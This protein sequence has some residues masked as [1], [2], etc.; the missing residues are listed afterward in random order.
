LDL[1]QVKNQLL[2]SLKIDHFEARHKT[3]TL[4]LRNQIVRA[5][6][7]AA[8]AFLWGCSTNGTTGAPSIPLLDS[9]DW[10]NAYRD[11]LES[12]YGDLPAWIKAN[13]DVYSTNSADDVAKRTTARNAASSDIMWLVDYHYASDIHIL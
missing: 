13:Y 10:E 9:H 12:K 1:C 11:K 5:L 2:D 4:M 3:G 8:L 7:C 6:I